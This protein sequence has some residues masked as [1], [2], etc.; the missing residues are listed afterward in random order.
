MTEPVLAARPDLV[1]CDECDAVHERID[2]PY[3]MVARCRRCNAML[4]RGRILRTQTL[5]A[6]SL[7]ALILLVVGNSAPIVTLDLN[8]VTSQA[9]LPEAI[10]H[11]WRSGEPLVALLTAAT[12]QVFPLVF[13]LLRIYLLGSLMQGFVPSGFVPAMR[14]LDFVTRWSMVEVFMMGTLVAV[15][16]GAT[17]TSAIPGIGLFA[18]GALALLLTAITAAGTSALWKRSSALG[19]QQAEEAAV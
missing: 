12:A 13:T 18:Y 2:L 14:A 10:R 17:L 9:T 11:T 15:V 1:V 4:G 7:A 6:F 3:G 5:L 8:G 16:R 19:P